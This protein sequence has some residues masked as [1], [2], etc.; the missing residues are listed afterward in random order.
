MT[1]SNVKLFDNFK[2]ISSI[3]HFNNWRLSPIPSPSQLP[4]TQ[5][6]PVASLLCIYVLTQFCMVAQLDPTDWYI[7]K[8]NYYIKLTIISDEKNVI[9]SPSIIET[10]N[11]VPLNRE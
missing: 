5:K 9:I 6:V 3:I 4:P 8:Q 11:S 1:Y 10:G 7:K 2:S